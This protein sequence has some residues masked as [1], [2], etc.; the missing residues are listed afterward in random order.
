MWTALFVVLGAWPLLS[1][2]HP[3]VLLLAAAGVMALVTVAVPRLLKPFNVAWHRFGLVLHK[4]VSPIV[5][6]ALF[7]GV[8]TPIAAAM[9]A[10]RKN[11]L[12]LRKPD[13]STYWHART[14]G[15]PGRGSMRDQF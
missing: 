4:V 11:L 5:L 8:L 13:V 7:Y 15:G 9:R 2:G 12:Q 14:P 6:G 3:R 10:S 1:G